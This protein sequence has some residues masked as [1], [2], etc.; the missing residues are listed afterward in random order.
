M[1]LCYVVYR[2]SNVSC[3]VSVAFLD[4]YCSTVQGLLDW[5]ELDSGFTE[6]LF[7]QID[8][9]FMSCIEDPTCR[10]MYPWQRL[11][12]RCATFQCFKSC[13][14]EPMRRVMC[15]WRRLVS[16]R[17]TNESLMACLKQSMCHV[18]YHSG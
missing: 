5:F 9:F 10:V 7:I 15:Q 12:S 3:H 8:L 1:S 4:G 14:K 13:T 17:R 6:L 16:S 11:V 18:M 2:R